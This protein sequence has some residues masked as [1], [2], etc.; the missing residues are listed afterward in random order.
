VR[1]VVGGGEWEGR[2]GV[3][4]YLSAW[5][6]ELLKGCCGLFNNVVL[7][8]NVIDTWFW[9]TRHSKVYIVKEAYHTLT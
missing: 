2:G 5:E 3:G 1:C 4:G 9:M 8:T 6:E 7:Q